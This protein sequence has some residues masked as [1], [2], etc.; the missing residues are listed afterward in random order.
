MATNN[1]LREDPEFIP[2]HTFQTIFLIVKTILLYLAFIHAI[3]LYVK[4]TGLSSP[5]PMIFMVFFFIVTMLLLYETVITY[6]PV[7]FFAIWMAHVGQ[8]L[9]LYQIIRPILHYMNSARKV[10]NILR[11]FGAIYFVIF[12]IGCSPSY[13]AFCQN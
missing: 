6:I 4:N 12:V 7:L 3:K 11:I 10:K 9:I 1:D 8:V 13:G 5:I 2:D